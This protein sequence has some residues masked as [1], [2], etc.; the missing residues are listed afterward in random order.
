MMLRALAVPSVILALAACA[1]HPYALSGSTV[2]ELRRVHGAP[3]HGVPGPWVMLGYRLGEDAMKRLGLS[4]EQ[5]HAVKVTHRAPAEFQYSCM[6]DGLL[7]ATGASPGKMNLWFEPVSSA[8]ELQTTIEDRKTGRTLRYRISE[9]A[10]KAFEGV[11]YK[12]FPDAAA[13][14]ADMP[15][16]ALFTVD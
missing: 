9:R 8:D 12:D 1:G 2:S 14:L 3:E 15:S 10:A 5:A 16:D 7:V 11:D 13:R 6:L 4:R